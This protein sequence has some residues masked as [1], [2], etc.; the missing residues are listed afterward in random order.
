MTVTSL[1]GCSKTR[2]IIVLPSN[3][4]AIDRVDIIDAMDIQTVTVYLEE[5][6]IGDNEYAI[7]SEFG[8]Y[9]DSNIFNNVTGGLHTLYVR[10]KNGCGIDSEKISVISIPK[11]F[12]PNGDGFNDTWQPLGISTEF[13]TDIS[14]YI[15]DR[16]GKLLKILDP[17]GPGWDGTFKGYS[18]PSSDYWYTVDFQELFSEKHRQFKGHFTLKR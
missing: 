1:E 16:Y 10:D 8:P 14:I 5:S 3:I 18:M 12:T 6:S 13:Q 4:P 17:F 7:D 2:E 9:Q 11:F 15:Y